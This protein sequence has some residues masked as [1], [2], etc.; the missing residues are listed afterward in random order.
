MSSDRQIDK[1][2]KIEQSAQVEVDRSK[3]KLNSFRK[4]VKKLKTSDAK[5]D[6]KFDMASYLREAKGRAEKKITLKYDLQFAGDRTEEELK[7]EDIFKSMSDKLGTIIKRFE[8]TFVPKVKVKTGQ[9]RKCPHCGQIWEKPEGC[10]GWTNCGAVPSGDRR[11]RTTFQQ[12]RFRYKGG[13]ELSVD[14]EKQS[15]RKLISHRRL[16]RKSKAGC[17]RKICWRNMKP[18]NLSTASL[19]RLTT[20]T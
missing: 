9:F 13:G 5:V 18:V 20:V 12:I 2:A 10:W 8:A 7:C 1:I 16:W 4:I 19:R 6:A 14:A 15:E 3:A 11:T 17:G